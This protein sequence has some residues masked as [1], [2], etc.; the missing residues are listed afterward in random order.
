M[1]KKV[2]AFLLGVTLIFSMMLPVFA[3]NSDQAF[4]VVEPTFGKNNEVITKNLLINIRIYEEIPLEMTLVRVEPNIANAVVREEISSL[5]D[6]SVHTIPVLIADD[7]EEVDLS[8]VEVPYEVQGSYTE[9]ERREIAEAYLQMLIDKQNA[10]EEFI[11]AFKE[12]KKLFYSE[13]MEIFVELTNL[14]YYELE[15]VSGYEKAL[16]SMLVTNKQYQLLKPVY[17]SIFESVVLGPEEVALDGVIPFYRTVVEDIKPGDYKL[18][19]TSNDD[20]IRTREFTV[21][22]LLEEKIKAGTTEILNNVI[23]EIEK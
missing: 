15:V 11:R 14:S 21:K 23:N 6:T 2:A 19:F 20:V 9:E 22:E 16:E 8:K 17:E 4:E 13:E 7:V 3:G 5:E 18:I 1:F 10:E 12:Y